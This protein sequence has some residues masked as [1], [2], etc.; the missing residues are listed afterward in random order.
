MKKFLI[1]TLFLFLISCGGKQE[2]KIKHS[3]IITDE[4]KANLNSSV[5]EAIEDAKALGYK[6]KINLSDLTIEVKEGCGFSPI[7]GTPSWREYAP[8]YNNTEWDINPDPNIGEIYA[9][10]LVKQKGDNLTT[11][12]VICNSNDMEYIRNVG[13]YGY[14]HIAH[15]FNDRKVYNETAIHIDTWHPILKSRLQ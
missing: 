7:S 1:T 11:E 13:R 4:L 10:E 6:N 15:Y 5:S 14:E 2:I 8:S 3:G 12:Y 9:A